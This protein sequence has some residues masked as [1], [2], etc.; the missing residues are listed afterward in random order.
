[1]SPHKIEA[2]A[3]MLFSQDRAH[4]TEVLIASLDEDLALED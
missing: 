4:L 1:M 3:L 2:E